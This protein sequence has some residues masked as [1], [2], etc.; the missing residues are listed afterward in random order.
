[1]G[2]MK[3]IQEEEDV[4]FESMV[5]FSSKYLCGQK[6]KKSVLNKT[7]SCI[8]PI[9]VSVT[10]SCVLKKAKLATLNSLVIAAAYQRRQK[11]PLNT[12]LNP[13]SIVPTMYTLQFFSVL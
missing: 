3:C 5:N 11:H 1:M 13:I 6:Q 2:K 10:N 7:P 9:Y 8:I 4:F 12:T